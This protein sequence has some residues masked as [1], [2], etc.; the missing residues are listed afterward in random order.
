[1]AE[2]DILPRLSAD[3]AWTYPEGADGAFRLHDH[4]EPAGWL[5]FDRVRSS[6]GWQGRSWSFEHAGPITIR[7]ASGELAGVFTPRPNGGGTVDLSSGRSYCWNRKHVLS[8]TWCFRSLDNQ[9][10]VCVSQEAGPLISGGA[11][12]LCPQA[13]QSP[14]TALLVLLAWYLR[15]LEFETLSNSQFVCG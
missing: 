15:V 8:R 10:T 14:D 2:P 13:A 12:T 7:A 5:K 11:V 4:G 1:M 6:A 3:L 9:S